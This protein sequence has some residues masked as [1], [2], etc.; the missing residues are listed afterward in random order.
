[1]NSL[2]LGMPQGVTRWDASPGGAAVF[3]AI[4][5]AVGAPGHTRPL[6]VDVA[7]SGWTRAAS[8]PHPPRLQADNMMWE[9]KRLRTCR[10]AI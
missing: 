2:C 1:M 4:L 5:R 9:Q 7:A 3:G 8:V 6:A 10:S